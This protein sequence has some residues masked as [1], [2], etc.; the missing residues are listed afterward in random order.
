MERERERLLAA[1]LEARSKSRKFL[2]VGEEGIC[3]RLARKKKREDFLQKA[4]ALVRGG[5]RSPHAN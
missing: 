1:R 2:R 3:P 5:G 4:A